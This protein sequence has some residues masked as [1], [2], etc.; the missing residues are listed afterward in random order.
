MGKKVKVFIGYNVVVD[1]LN[2]GLEL[3]IDNSWEMN[4]EL[5]LDMYV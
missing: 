2:I 1:Y 4:Y 3:L 5:I